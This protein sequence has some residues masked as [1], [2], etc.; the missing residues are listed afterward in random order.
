MGSKVLKGLKDQ[1]KEL[2]D[3]MKVQKQDEKTAKEEYKEA[4]SEAGLFA[5]KD[6]NTKVQM[7][8]MTYEREKME[9]R[10]GK[11]LQEQGQTMEKMVGSESRS[12]GIFHSDKNLSTKTKDEMTKHNQAVSSFLENGVG[13]VGADTASKKLEKS[14]AKDQSATQF[15]DT[16]VLDEATAKVEN[17]VKKKAERQLPN[18]LTSLIGGKSDKDTGLSL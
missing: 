5:S 8:K 16:S 7:A 18:I 3:V 9:T 17:E 1:N 12:F 15:Q 2:K 14:L 6:E 4:K 10:Y 11:S 13:S